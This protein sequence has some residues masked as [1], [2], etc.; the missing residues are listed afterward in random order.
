MLKLVMGVIIT[1]MPGWESVRYQGFLYP[2]MQSCL[3]SNELYVQD[4]KQ[5]A[6]NRG[7]DAAHFSSICF[8]VDSYP[9]KK[10]DNMVL[11]I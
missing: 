8:E 5:I 9:I 11:G 4:Y 6:K 2:D 3:A 7:D 10:F 1:T